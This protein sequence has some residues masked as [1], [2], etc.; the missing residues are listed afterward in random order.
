MFGTL[1]DGIF[2]YASLFLPFS[3]PGLNFAHSLGSPSSFVNS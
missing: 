2:Q 1:L 3:E